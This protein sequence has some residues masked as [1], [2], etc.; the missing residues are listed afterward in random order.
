MVFNVK[1]FSSFLNFYLSMVRVAD[2]SL[3][4]VEGE[5]R[6]SDTVNLF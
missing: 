1:L 4:R 3:K 2:G 6:E 5:T